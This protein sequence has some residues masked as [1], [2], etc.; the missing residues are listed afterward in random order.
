MTIHV[1]HAR[2]RLG[3]SRRGHH[4]QAIGHQGQGKQ[5]TDDEGT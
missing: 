5:A 3:R 1:V 4:G 2:F